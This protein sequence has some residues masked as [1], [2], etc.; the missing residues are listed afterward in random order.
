MKPKIKVVY[1]KVTNPHLCIAKYYPR[2][3]GGR[4][5]PENI[6]DVIIKLDPILKKPQN[7]KFIKPIL[8]HETDEI[9]ARNKGQSLNKAHRT[10]MKKEP[11]WFKK[12]PTDRILQKK[13]R[14]EF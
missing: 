8:K 9:R 4:G 1:R 6:T 3:Y 2:G 12:F 11:R 10:A 7:K 14:E 5:K 13:L